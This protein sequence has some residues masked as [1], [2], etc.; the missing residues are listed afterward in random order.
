MWANYQVR[1]TSGTGKGQI[2][3]IASN[4]GTVL[5]ISPN[6]TVN[7]DATS[8]YA[9]EGNDDN[10]YLLGNNAVTLYKFVVSTNTWSTLTPVAARAGAYAAGGTADWIDGVAG[11][12]NETQ[13][14]HYSG[15]IFKQNGRYIFAFRGGASSTL[16]VYDIAANTW[17]SGVAYGGQME[18]FTTGSHSID[19]DGQIFLTKEATGRI[20]RFDVDFNRM[21][22]VATNTNQVAL[23][24][25][26][27]VGNKMFILPFN[28]G[29]TEVVFGY[30]LR[31]SASD[32]VRML[33]F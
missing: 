9:I 16:D 31:H 3:A 18:T 24:G 20:F 15:T 33:L 19:L 23:G 4:T 32:L 17:I 30:M 7:P 5:T 10:F 27:V 14:N 6:W 1:I 13:I 8:V 2:R 12:N 25:T 28:D 11:W 22:P 29:G 26:A 21:V